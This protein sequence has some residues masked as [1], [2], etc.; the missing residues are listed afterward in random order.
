VCPSQP[1]DDTKAGELLMHWKAELL[2]R[3]T[4]TAWT[5][6][7]TGASKSEA[8]AKPCTWDG[9]TPR[10]STG[11]GRAGQKGALQK[12]SRGSR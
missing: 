11:W 2:F 12:S 5:Q 8:R 9:V 1:A 6:G 10:D 4:Y 3:E 7:L